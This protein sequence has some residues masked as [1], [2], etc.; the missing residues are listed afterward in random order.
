MKLKAIVDEILEWTVI[1]TTLMW[2]IL[3]TVLPYLKGVEESPTFAMYFT[4]QWQET[5]QVSLTNFLSIVFQ[6][7]NCCTYRFLLKMLAM[8]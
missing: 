5:L 6:V 8:W 1:Q 4:K 2:T 3:S 7:R